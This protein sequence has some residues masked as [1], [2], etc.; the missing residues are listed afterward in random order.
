MSQHTKSSPF[1]G[2]F[3]GA[4]ARTEIGTFVTGVEQRGI[5]GYVGR[6]S[7]DRRLGGYVQANRPLIGTR[8]T[9]IRTRTGSV[10]TATGSFRTA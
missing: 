2:S 9:P 10:R 3:T 4:A 8:T 6:V 5:G 7:E 1:G